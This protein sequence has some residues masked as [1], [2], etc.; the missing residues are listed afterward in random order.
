M[1]TAPQSNREASVALEP[2]IDSRPGEL[3]ELRNEA[4]SLRRNLSEVIRLQNEWI[5]LAAHELRTPLT[6]LNLNLEMASRRVGSPAASASATEFLKHAREDTIRI[7]ELMDQLWK[8]CEGKDP[9]AVTALSHGDMRTIVKKSI[10]QIR[11]RH[12]HSLFEVSLPPADGGIDWAVITD[13]IRLEQ[14][15]INLCENAWKYG[16]GQPVRVTLTPCIDPDY[17]TRRPCGFLVSICDSGDG[18]AP[19]QLELLFQ[20]RE[21]LPEHRNIEGTGWGLYVVRRIAD[22]LGVKIT[23]ISERK[24]GTCF[25]V[26]IPSTQNRS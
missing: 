22:A 26:Q 8:A 15:L 20:K 9:L 1:S 24:K 18:I 16:N 25:Q 2:V 17:S 23:V 21:R 5:Q 19:E 7:I 12:E 4:A 3:V 10:R 6:S 11:N 14:V 13:P